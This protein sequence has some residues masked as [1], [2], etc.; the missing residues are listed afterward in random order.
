[1]YTKKNTKLMS[2]TD[3]KKLVSKICAIICIVCSLAST[4][5][6]VLLIT[7]SDTGLSITSFS[8]YA[9]FLVLFYVINA[10]YNFFPFE[11]RAKKVFFRLSHAFFITII[12][13][14]YIPLCLIVLKGAWGWTFF[15]IIIALAVF[16]IVM[17]SIYVYRWRGATETCY[18]FIIN[19]AWLIAIAKVLETIG[20]KAMVVYLMGFLILNISMLFYRLAAYE[21]NKRYLLFMPLF[22]FFLI[23]S[24]ICHA[25]FM[26]LFLT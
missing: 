10:I 26:F 25:V 22:Y 14:A 4:T 2:N 13:G 20:E 11:F 18:Y 9:G 17:R 21:V 23:L 3:V 24:N 16:G 15:G 8:L 6:L 7:L 1:M 12:L 19:W 5:I